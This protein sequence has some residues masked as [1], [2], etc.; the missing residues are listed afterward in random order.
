[1][2]VE[3]AEPVGGLLTEIDRAVRGRL[4]KGVQVARTILILDGAT[5][6]PARVAPAVGGQAERSITCIVSLAIGEDERPPT[7]LR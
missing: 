7:D 5:E 3:S 2:W 4:L 6:R 1:M